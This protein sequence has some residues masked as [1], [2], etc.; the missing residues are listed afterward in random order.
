MNID[1]LKIENTFLKPVKMEI[2]SKWRNETRNYNL[3]GGALI[4]R[5]AKKVTISVEL[6]ALEFADYEALVTAFDKIFFDVMYYDKGDFLT[7]EFFVEEYT[8][9]S[10]LVLSANEKYFLGAALKLEEK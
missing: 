4:D 10:P 5:G 2:N 3:S 9:P 7:G 6:G 1:F 8:E